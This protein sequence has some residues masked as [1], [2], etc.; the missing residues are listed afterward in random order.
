MNDMLTRFALTLAPQDSEILADVRDYVEWQAGRQSPFAPSASD[1]VGLRT[2]LL[3]LHI[4]GVEVDQGAL[5]RKIASLM[6]FYGWAEAEGLIT[7][8]PFDRFDFDRPIL[9][10]D[11]IQQRQAAPAAGQE[12]D[13]ARLRALNRLIADLNGSADMRAVLDATLETLVEVMGLRTAWVSLL[14]GAGFPGQTADASSSDFVLA[15]THGLPPGL[16]QDD[17]HY[18]RRPP[19]CH[20]QSLLRAG[21]LTHA[22]NV[23]ECTRLQSAAEAA[24]D[25]Q[26][27][28]FHATVP[29]I[30]QGRPL[31]ILNV[32]T[33]EWQF[34]T[35]PDLQLL[36]AA[37]MQI[38]VALE[39]T[40]LVE[41]AQSQ[42]VRLE[43]ELEMARI[44]QASLL[45]RQLPCIPGFNLA[46]D[47]RSEREVAGDFYD[48][49][50]L[51]DGRWGIVVADVCEKGAPA[52]L[53]MV[54]ARSLIRARAE[55]TPS[56]AAT[57]MEVNRA[58]AEQSSAGLFVTVFYAILDP[59]TCTL[60]F[61][62][63]G[64][65]PPIV[66]RASA[67][68]PTAPLPGGGL[69]LGMF[70][71]ISLSD[72]AINLAPGDVLTLYT[73]G[74]TE[75]FNAGGEMFGAERLIQIV[76]TH[77]AA[78]A[79]EL[80]EAIMAQANAFAGEAPQSDDMTLL[81]IRCQSSRP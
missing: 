42:R 35:A 77:P 8:T 17:H 56:P 61:T 28:R 81:V 25:T 22:V 12:R 71:E 27:L 72:A 57:L 63:A 34:L 59:T 7:S 44:V 6:R 41:L 67:Q 46:A 37:G 3:E 16:E 54:L 2:Y 31:G 11:Q 62:I 40:R 19:D 69:P 18:L 29:I 15:A 47:W 50:P 55:Q 26:G 13:I 73:D 9:S 48:V 76:H 53:Y 14:A 1:D 64:H 79:E 43:R 24:G 21:R 68:A 49:F 33:D 4:A 36:S 65:N 70:D 39:R 20:C 78:S 10:R 52:A 60:D 32:A 5:H 30:F 38:A 58:L 45:P 74:L 66:R 51:A 80:L 75:A 23:V